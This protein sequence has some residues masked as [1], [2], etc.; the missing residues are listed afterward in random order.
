MMDDEGDDDDDDPPRHE[1][2]L[3]GILCAAQLNRA[4]DRG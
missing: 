1:D 2:Y 4:Q 3:C